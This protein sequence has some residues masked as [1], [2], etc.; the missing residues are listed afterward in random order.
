MGKGKLASSVQPIIKRKKIVRAAGHHG[1]AWKVAYADFVTAMMAFFLL[2]WLLNATTEDQRKGIADYFNPTIPVSRISG[3]GNDALNGDSVFTE[4][5]MAQNGRGVKETETY[6]DNSEIDVKDLGLDYPATSEVKTDYHK[7]SAD[8]AQSVESFREA[9]DGQAR[10]IAEHIMLK[11]TPEGLVIELVE[12]D[13]APLF[14]IGQADP[15]P[16]LEDLLDLV[17]NS[18]SGIKNNVKV[19]GHTDA[20]PYR[21][22]DGYSNWELSTDRANTSRRL[23]VA[24]GFPADQIKEVS[25]RADTE[26]LLDDPF[27]PQ[28]RRISITILQ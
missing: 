19:V 11:M 13:G 20:K 17:A 3:G 26:P 14:T 4:D 21:S 18:F 23:L 22:N 16:L 2:M 12:A 24:A 8:T 5:D 9:I 27:A 10:Q 7:V 25:G 28:N 1:G 15:S 6:K